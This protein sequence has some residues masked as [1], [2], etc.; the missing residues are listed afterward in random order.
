M[1]VCRI[2][3]V[4]QPAIS[5]IYILLGDFERS[6]MPIQQVVLTCLF[7]PS[8]I[9]ILGPIYA[10]LTSSISSDTILNLAIAS[11]VIRLL[12]YDYNNGTYT[13]VSLNS[14]L[15]GAI[16]LSSRLQT[17]LAATIL[18]GCALIIFRWSMRMSTGNQVVIFCL[19]QLSQAVFNHDYQLAALSA[20]LQ[21]CF[22]ILGP[23]LL[24]HDHFLKRKNRIY[25]LWDEAEMDLTK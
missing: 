23:Y 3:P 11:L 13:A 1:C 20:L 4:I 17:S 21:F 10:D 15:F 2:A 7:F 25:G 18:V 19:L 12:F 22:C 6:K 9:I 5:M 24:C 8:V 16:I 14:A